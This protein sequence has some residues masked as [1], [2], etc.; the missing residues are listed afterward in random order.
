[1]NTNELIDILHNEVR[2]YNDYYDGCFDYKENVGLN[3]LWLCGLAV[4]RVHKKSK[5][6]R[7]SIPNKYLPLFNLNQDAYV[8]K[9]EPFWTNIAYNEDVGNIIIKYIGDVFSKCFFKSAAEIFG[10]CSR[11]LECSNEKLCVHPDKERARGCMYKINLD[12]GRIFYGEN[13]N[14]D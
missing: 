1:M 3:T 5:D 13:R 2:S 10:C 12:D 9:E 7:I 11:Y 6:D 8:I 14:I 4:L